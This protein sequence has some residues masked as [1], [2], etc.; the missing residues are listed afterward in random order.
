MCKTV[1]CMCKKD[2]CMCKQDTH[3]CET[4]THIYMCHRHKNVPATYIIYTFKPKTRLQIEFEG[5]KYRNG[6]L[7]KR[8]TKLH[9]S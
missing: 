9:N 1:T 4:D 3:M 2:T 6:K 7:S 5:F 8:S